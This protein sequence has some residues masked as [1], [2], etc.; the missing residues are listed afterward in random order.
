MKNDFA[1]PQRIGTKQMARISFLAVIGFVLEMINFPLPIFPG[2]LKFDFSSLPSL[3]GGMLM[4]PLPAVFIELIK[5]LLKVIVQSETIGIGEVSNFICGIS[6]AVPAAVIYRK[7]KGYKGFIIGGITGVIMLTVVAS[8]SNYFFVIPAY[9]F[10]FGG[11][12]A[13][14]G[15]ASKVNGNI[16]DLKTIIMLAIIPF[17]IIK[18]SATV[19]AGAVI[20]RH[21]PIF[22]KEK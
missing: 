4:G 7:M 11:M 16:H 5:N 21:L 10:A 18:G 20:Y 3:I 9:A 12:E 1:L 17:N 6:L 8:L 13:I 2:F 15:L 22:E 14:I 19:L